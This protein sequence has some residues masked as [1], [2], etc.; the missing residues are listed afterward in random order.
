MTAERGL[1][2][3]N[4]I[5]EAKRTHLSLLMSTS[6]T[7]PQ[8]P[9]RKENS[10]LGGD[11]RPFWERT[12]LVVTETKYMGWMSPRQRRKQQFRRSVSR[13]HMS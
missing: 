13:R 7:K 5:R 6:D 8:A 2:G 10:R 12:G 1:R 9:E 3:P 11:G 4:P